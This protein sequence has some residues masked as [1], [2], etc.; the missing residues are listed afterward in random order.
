MAAKAYCLEFE[1]KRLMKALKTEKQKRNRG[2]RLNLLVEKV[3]GLQLFLPSRVQAACNFANDKKVEKEKCRVEKSR[4][5]KEES[6]RGE[7]KK[8]R[9]DA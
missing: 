5:A 7:R 2:K 3:Y 1:D 9:K 4:V 8:A 6:T